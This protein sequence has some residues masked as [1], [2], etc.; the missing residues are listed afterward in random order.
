MRNWIRGVNLGGWLVLERW[1]TPYLFAIT[2]CHLAG[3]WCTYPGQGSSVLGVENHDLFLCYET[4]ECKPILVE[5]PVTKQ[6]D[7]PWDEYTLLQQFH[8]K[9]LVAKEYLR[10]H[11]D[12]FVTRQDIQDLAKAG[13]THVRVPLPHW[14]Q[15]NQQDQ[16]S[17]YLV[18]EAWMYFLRVVDWC[19]EYHIQV[20]P[21]LHTAPGSQN[22]F[23][24][25]GKTNLEGAT[26]SDWNSNKTLIALQSILVAIHNDGIKDVVTGIGILNEPYMDCSLQEIKD[27]NRKALK[28]V[29]DI[30][31]NTTAVVIGDLF[32]ATLW[33][34]GYWENEPNTFLDS[35]YYHGTLV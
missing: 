32:N 25:S 11:Y 18:H 14:I 24:N 21:D 4:R 33:N 2:S 8:D 9:P 27:Y 19:R 20:W 3:N 31:G 12:A 26:C 29:R 6:Q 30:L 15:S 7:Y 10:R 23:D 34:D 28:L 13:I 22:G 5:N 17:P 1:I 35:H 16:A